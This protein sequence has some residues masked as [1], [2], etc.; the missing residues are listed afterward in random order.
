MKNKM[1]K[2]I[3]VLMVFSMFDLSAATAATKKVT[4]PK[5][6]LSVTQKTTSSATMK[7]SFITSSRPTTQYVAVKCLAYSSVVCAFP[8]SF[9]KA[10]NGDYYLNISKS[11]RSYTIS[12]LTP[13]AIYDFK[14]YSGQT[15]NSKSIIDYTTLRLD[16]GVEAPKNL[17]AVWSLSGINKTVNLTWQKPIGYSGGYTLEVRNTS[18]SSLL[19][20]YEIVAGL[21]SFTVPDLLVNNTYK[22]SLFGM[23]GF[24]G[25][26]AEFTL[27]SVNPE[28]LIGFDLVGL[29]ESSLKVI[30]AKP[31]ATNLSLNLAI[32]SENVGSLRIGDKVVTGANTGEFIITGLSKGATYSISGYLSNSYGNSLADSKS[33][34]ISAQPGIVTGLTATPGENNS[35]NLSWQRPD[36]D[37]GVTITDYLVEYKLATSST[38]STFNDGVSTN[39]STILTDLQAASSYNLRVASVN[40]NGVS[41]YNSVVATTF[42]APSAPLALTSTIID[43]NSIT[44]SWSPP[45][46][47]GGSPVTDYLI[48]YS[49]DG[50]SNW[51]SYSDSIT[52]ATSSVVNGLTPLAAY[53]FRVKAVNKVGTSVPSNSTTITMSTLPSAPSNLLLVGKT[54]TS[55]DFSWTAP[56]SNGGRD[57]TDYIIE[58]SVG[59]TGV[60][61]VFSD[62]VSTAARANVTGLAVATS[63]LFRVK[64]VT[65]LG[66]SAYSNPTLS[67]ATSG[68]VTSAPLNLVAATGNGQVQLSWTVPA[69]I[70]NSPITDYI[71]EISS[72]SG[73][74]WSVVNDGT[75]TSLSYTVGGLSNGQ[76]YQFRVAAVNAIGNSSY[77]NTVSTNVLDIPSQVLNL[78]P[79]VGAPKSITLAW[80]APTTSNGSNIIDYVIDYSSNAGVTYTVFVDGVSATPGATITGLLDNTNYLVRV[81]AKN[82]VGEGINSSVVNA[83]TWNV[84]GAPTSL[85]AVSPSA[86]S[87]TVTW[88]APASNGGTNITDYIVEYS[89]NAGSTYTVFVDGVS[90]ALSSTISGLNVNSNYLVRVRAVNAVG[91]SLNSSTIGVADAPTNVTLSVTGA[92]Q[93]TATWVAP[94]NVNGSAIT[95]YEIDVDSGAGYSTAVDGVGTGTTFVINSVT[96][97]SFRS[98]RVRAI[99]ALGESV[100]T[101]VVTGTIFSAPGAPTALVVSATSATQLSAS[102]SAPANNGGSAITDYVVEYSSD[103]GSTFTIANDGVSTATSS[104]IGSLS[105]GTSYLVRVRAKNVV[106]EG[107]YTANVS[108]T[109]SNGAP[110]APTGLSLSVISSTQINATWVAPAS[111]GGSAITDYVVEISTNGGGSYTVFVDGTSTTASTNIT[112]LTASTSYVVRIKAVNSVGT[113][114]ASSTQTAAT[115]A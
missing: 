88:V 51:L 65:I 69:T 76:S 90:T 110:G 43:V 95:D 102:W 13:G 49:L 78:S 104:T 18:S 66:S 42:S 59:S 52:S 58:Y 92:N 19:K 17:S 83:T 38:W 100:N 84:P 24:K 103:G 11:A 89:S 112:G 93:L 2:V 33:L 99:N 32:T 68:A 23:E 48:D 80:N 75:S 61:S 12:G 9:K 85:S 45:T 79:T 37:G 4:Y 47:N 77:S 71:V 22:F 6:E 70:G 44:L 98:V 94:S 30:W 26:V 114:V 111:N 21:E 109:T 56:T 46:L 108:G 97:G 106:G 87:V 28:K 8:S 20:S 40:I 27:S 3:S 115:T 55:V 16:R 73:T 41:S 74:S 53:S 62:S 39:L 35:I 10:S 86:G 67:V 60:W 72:N 31:I 14:V 81:R 5:G 1:I 34:T 36:T 29:T 96:A 101:A 7:W 54:D 105:A 64:S 57:I 113:S 107:D 15:F 91:E 50:G 63:Y 82:G 25:A